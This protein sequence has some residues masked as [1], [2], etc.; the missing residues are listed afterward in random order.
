MLVF[1]LHWR[2][3][4][5]DESFVDELR[6]TLRFFAS[7]LIRR[8][9]KV[10]VYNEKFGTFM[11]TK[12]SFKNLL[13]TLFTFNFFKIKRWMDHFWFINQFYFNAWISWFVEIRNKGNYKENS[14]VPFWWIYC[15]NGNDYDLFF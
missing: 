8:I 13:F 10:Y 11:I 4:T 15:I 5:D 9:H 6:V 3:V 2:D 7:V 14:H 1:L 12:E